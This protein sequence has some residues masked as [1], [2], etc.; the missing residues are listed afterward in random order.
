MKNLTIIQERMSKTKNMILTI[1]I[2]ERQSIDQNHDLYFIRAFVNLRKL[3]NVNLD[4]Q[5]KI[6]QIKRMGNK[7]ICVFRND[8][9][10]ILKQSIE[11][12]FIWCKNNNEPEIIFNEHEITHITLNELNELALQYNMHVYITTERQ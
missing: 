12:L 2:D 5:I 10:Q 11:L 9:E 1:G 7:Q 4:H 6:E 8:N 3:L